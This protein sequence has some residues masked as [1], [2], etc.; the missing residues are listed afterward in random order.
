MNPVYQFMKS[1]DPEV[2][3]VVNR[4]KEARENWVQ[5]VSQWASDLTGI[6]T[7]EVSVWTRGWA[8]DRI[9]V[10]G[11]DPRQVAQAGVK[12]PGKW[13]K[14]PMRPYKNNPL[15]AEVPKAYRA[16]KVP[17]RPNVA[18]GLSRMGAGALFVYQGIA[19]S[20]FSFKPEDTASDADGAR[21]QEIKPSEYY[22]AAEAYEETNA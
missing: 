9:R 21:W 5:Q 17:G 2:V 20:A 6:S 11:L 10:T 4:R 14:D 18:Y 8:N 13:T 15:S 16:E 7:D 19:Y 1:T 3:A 12:L 22:A